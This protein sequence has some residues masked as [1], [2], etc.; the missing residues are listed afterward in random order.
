M[1]TPSEKSPD[2]SEVRLILASGSPRRRELIKL[3]NV[4]SEVATSDVEE[5]NPLEGESAVEYV[6]R[7]AIAKAR[8]VAS[9]EGSG[10]VLGADT[11]VV[12]DG[13]VLGKPH[14]ESEAVNMLQRLRGST[15]EIITGI[16][17]VEACSDRCLSS[18][19]S[20]W[21]K[22]REYSD[23]EIADYVASG[24][25]MDKAGAY[26]VQDEVFRPAKVVTGCYTNVVGL[27]ICEVIGMFESLGANVQ[28]K[29]SNTAPEGCENCTLSALGKAMEV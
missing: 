27:P 11:V 29:R 9:Q 8:C 26:A 7:L 5:G 13:E 12:L 4:V 2:S 15:H 18:T 23:H 20:T 16:A 25:P 6:A 14:D 24:E 17:I 19:K 1:S 22:L 10:Y 28:M 3:F 21:I